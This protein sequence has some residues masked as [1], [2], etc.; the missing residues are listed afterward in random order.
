MRSGDCGAGVDPALLGLVACGAA[1]AADRR[2]VPIPEHIHNSPPPLLSL[3]LSLSLPRRQKLE[4][5]R[6]N[7]NTGID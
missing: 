7:Y 2:F 3:S 1:F 6:P 4:I 5:I